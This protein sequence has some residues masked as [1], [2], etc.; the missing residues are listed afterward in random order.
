MRDTLCKAGKVSNFYFRLKKN[1]KKP[2]LNKI[3]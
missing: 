2:R 3:N 1:K